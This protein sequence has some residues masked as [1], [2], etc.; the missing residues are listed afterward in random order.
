MRRSAIVL[1]TFLILGLGF[2][3]L[4]V[5]K[6]PSMKNRIGASAP[7]LE[8]QTSTGRVDLRSMLGEQTIVIVYSP[9]CPHCEHQLAE[10]EKA[11]PPQ[12]VKIYLIK[13][14]TDSSSVDTS[15][16]VQ[17]APRVHL[18]GATAS[19]VMGRLKVSLVP[20]SLV[21]D[22]LKIIRRAYSGMVRMDS[23][24]RKIDYPK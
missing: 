22:S 23:L 17:I 8:I 4:A 19:T 13:V 12:H 18:V 10:I 9:T 7:N 14:I 2:L 3:V 1:V 20:T 16:F 5:L 21:F 15:S 11:P 24:Y 6:K